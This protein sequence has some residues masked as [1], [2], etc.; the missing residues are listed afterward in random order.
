MWPQ[1][2]WRTRMFNRPTTS[3]GITLFFTVTLWATTAHTEQTQ[4][5]DS[6][7]ASVPAGWA[8]S[9]VRT[10]SS[11]GQWRSGNNQYKQFKMFIL[12]KL[13]SKHHYICEHPKNN[14][15]PPGYVVERANIPWG[16]CPPSGK[17]AL[18][19]KFD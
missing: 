13:D 12:V 8:I 5:C 1:M 2:F 18:I 17:K 3:I 16:D 15:P 9:A 14:M 11:C 10:S 19:R 7:T 4:M 6:A